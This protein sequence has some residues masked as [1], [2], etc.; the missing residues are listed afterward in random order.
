MEV[1]KHAVHAAD[2]PL[3]ADL[4]SWQQPPSP[5]AEG[6]DLVLANTNV[7]WAESVP[8]WHPQRGF[9]DSRLSGFEGVVLMNMTFG[10]RVNGRCI[11]T[12]CI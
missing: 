7:G 12:G 1:P 10:C 6:H 5:S 9:E 8:R 11:C 3:G 4:K 2:C